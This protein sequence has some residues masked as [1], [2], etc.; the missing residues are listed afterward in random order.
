[1]GMNEARLRVQTN[2][3]VTTIFSTQDIVECCRYSQGMCWLSKT[4]EYNTPYI[5]HSGKTKNVN[6]ESKEINI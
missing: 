5:I 1:M 3:T 2:N 6:L 4:K